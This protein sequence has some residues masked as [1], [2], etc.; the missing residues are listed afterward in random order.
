MSHSASLLK[1]L[2]DLEKRSAGLRREREETSEWKS[3]E[4]GKEALV[5]CF[6]FVP[7]SLFLPPP[8]VLS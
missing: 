6:K 4:I 8:F 1:D 5:K 2:E 3:V 7:F